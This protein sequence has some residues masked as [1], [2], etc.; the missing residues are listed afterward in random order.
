ME[1][2][3]KYI[4]VGKEHATTLMALI[5]VTGE[6]ERQIRKEIARL[7]EEGEL[8]CNEQDGRGYYYAT[9]LDEVLKQYRQDRSRFLSIA[10][11]IKTARRIL[12]RAGLLDEEKESPTYEQMTLFDDDP[13]TT[14]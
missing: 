7:R 12:K 4:G 11:R 6:P 10:K 9:E 5:W 2:L 13:L 3:V 14:T 1:E 8:I